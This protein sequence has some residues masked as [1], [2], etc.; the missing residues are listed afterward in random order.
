M[1]GRG[2]TVSRW[3]AVGVLVVLAG[4]AGTIALVQAHS[5]P[6]EVRIA[7]Q[8]HEDGRIE[9]AIQQREGDEWG[10]RIR[11]S[12]RFLPA[13]PSIGR[14]L[15]ST[16]V[17]IGEFDEVS[18]GAPFGLPDGVDKMTAVS[19]NGVE[20]TLEQDPLTGQL[21][22]TVTADVEG[23]YGPELMLRCSKTG[24]LTVSVG[25]SAYSDGEVLWKLDDG[26][27]SREIWSAG[28]HGYEPDDARWFMQKL[29]GAD[30]L[31]VSLPHSS[32]PYMIDVHGITETPAQP[33]FD[34][35]GTY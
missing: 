33:N 28:D 26:L 21:E 7:A 30:R 3:L 35:C 25:S 12:S 6:S 19:S 27:A 22:T 14:W 23:W 9:F 2:L 16:P 29:H 13:E 10:N 18:E 17:T 11:P 31:T 32:E 4:L 20:F 1:P 34:Q 24:L 8:K 15:S 5:A